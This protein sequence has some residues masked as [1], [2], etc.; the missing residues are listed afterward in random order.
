MENE[1]LE[2][3]QDSSCDIEYYICGRGIYLIIIGAVSIFTLFALVM[4]IYGATYQKAVYGKSWMDDIV[5]A[6]KIREQEKID[7]INNITNAWKQFM[8]DYPDTA[9]GILLFDDFQKL[10]KHSCYN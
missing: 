3:S 2:Q 1:E 10:S 9:R 5:I 4:F 7:R 8:N 6:E